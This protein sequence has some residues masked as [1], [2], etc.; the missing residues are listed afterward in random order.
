MSKKAFFENLDTYKEQ[1]ANKNFAFSELT[2]A[3]KYMGNRNTTRKQWE[4]IRKTVALIYF[5]APKEVRD[6]AF[7]T[8]L[9]MTMRE[10]YMEKLW[11]NK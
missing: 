6:L 5:Y 10:H 4:Q 2:L 1:F 11:E 3:R 9:E 8:L 7:T